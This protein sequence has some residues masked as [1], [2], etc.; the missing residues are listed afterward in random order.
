MRVLYDGHG[1]MGKLTFTCK[2]QAGMASKREEATRDRRRREVWTEKRLN[3]STPRLHTPSTA[4]DDPVAAIAGYIL[5][6][7]P[8]SC[9]LSIIL[10][11]AC[12]AAKLTLPLLALSLQLVTLL[13]ALSLQ[14]VH[15]QGKE[16]KHSAR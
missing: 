9:Y 14:P 10:S 15:Y 5:T 11:S 1:G 13:L 3:R 7:R 8:S 6:C 16:Q 2:I 12:L 4:K